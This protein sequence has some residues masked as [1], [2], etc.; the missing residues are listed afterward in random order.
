[1]STDKR[2]GWLADLQPGDKVIVS[3]AGNGRD[4]LGFVER[5]TPAGK[6]RIKDSLTTYG[7]NGWNIGSHGWS[8]TSL[9]P[10]TP[11][12]IAAIAAVEARHAAITRLEAMVLRVRDGSCD[13]QAVLDALATVKAKP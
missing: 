11:K 7:A 13:P 6:I 2:T 8:R 3:A 4:R 12:A 9:D 5:I 1:M 10:A